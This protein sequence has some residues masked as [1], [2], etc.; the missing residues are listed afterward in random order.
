MASR[1]CF[2]IVRKNDIPIYVA[3]VGTA[4]RV[5]NAIF[6]FLFWCGFIRYLVN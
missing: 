3:E 6:F 4:P 1:A 2:V 5:G